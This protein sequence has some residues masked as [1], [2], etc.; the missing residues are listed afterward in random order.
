MVGDG[1]S[2]LPQLL[3]ARNERL[4]AAV[5]V[6][7][8]IFGMNMQ[9]NKAHIQ[10][11]SGVYVSSFLSLW[12]RQLLDTGGYESVARSAKARLGV[13]VAQ[14]RGLLKLIRQRIKPIELIYAADGLHLL[15]RGLDDLV[16]ICRIAVYLAVYAVF[17]SFSTL[18]DMISIAATGAPIVV[19]RS[20]ICSLF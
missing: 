8:R 4:D 19:S 18:A 14:K 15:C 7:Q 11:S 12:L 3:C 13:C 6:E 20:S 1:K 10:S 2:G 9:V 16:G 17:M 5:A